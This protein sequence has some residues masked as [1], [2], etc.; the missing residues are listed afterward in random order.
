[1]GEV[2]NLVGV[3]I[4]LRRECR[5]AGGQRAWASAHTISEQYVS[6][7]LNG[8]RAPGNAILS[9]LRLERV[10]AYRTTSRDA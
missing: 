5:R 9:A 4:R 10:V 6:D 2:L 8:R 3:V 7:V 1:M